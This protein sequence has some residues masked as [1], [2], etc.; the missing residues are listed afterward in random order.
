[1]SIFSFA[2]MGAGN[3][4]GHFASAIQLLKECEISAVASKSMERAQSF[5]DRYGIAYAYDNYEKMLQEVHVDCVYIATTTDSHYQLC[6]LCMKYHVPVLCEKAMFQNS[7][8]AKEVFDYSEREGIFTMEALW[9]KFLPAYGQAKQWLKGG[10]IGRPVFINTSI[11]FKAPEDVK[12]RYFNLALGGGA[13]YDIT[14]YAY[15]LTLDI[16]EQPVR[17]SSIYV[18]WGKSGAD[19]SEQISIRFESCMAMLQTSFMTK[20]DETM[21]IHGEEGRIIL[22]SPHMSKEAFLYDSD[23]KQIEHYTDT[24]TKN[25]FVYEI[26]EVMKCINEVLHESRTQPHSATLQ[27]TRLFDEIFATM[28]GT[29]F[30]D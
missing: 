28:P 27:C 10:R 20:L 13:A 18:E 4:A 8:Q 25:G 15:E 21:I 19:V 22:P 23:N 7:V 26:E 9:S 14:V 11:G 1:M 29:Q 30:T 24:M 2:I 3:I 5:S 17:N 6:M 12:N 16:L